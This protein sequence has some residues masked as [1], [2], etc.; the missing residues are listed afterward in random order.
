ML[1]PLFTLLDPKAPKAQRLRGL[2][3]LYGVAALL[4]LPI[5]SLVVPLT[6][7]DAPDPRTGYVF[8]GLWLGALLLIEWLGFRILR[9]KKTTVLAQVALMDGGLFG[10]ALVLAILLMHYSMTGW[11]WGLVVLGLLWLLRGFFRLALRV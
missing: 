5:S 6:P 10:M 3:V 9:S 4:Q 1:D 11:A 7:P 2:M 8:M